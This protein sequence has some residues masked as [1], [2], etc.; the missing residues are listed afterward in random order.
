MST[1]LTLSIE[2]LTCASCVARVEKAIAKV[3][4]VEQAS[5][6]LATEAATIT[7]AGAPPAAAVAQ[8]IVD[9]GY[10]VGHQDITL[11]IRGMTCASC[12]SRVEKALKTVPGV[13]AAEVNLA[14]ERATVHVL[15]S[16]TSSAALVAAVTRAGYEAAVHAEDQAV[17]AGEEQRDLWRDRMP[18]IAGV[19]LS[20]PL[21]LPMFGD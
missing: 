5:V 8:A 1:T 11:D 13:T 16:A 3:P 19:L 20:A 2:G 7:S 6:N 10:E 9:A 14:T 17:T 12:V 18:V 15:K 4:G 21:A